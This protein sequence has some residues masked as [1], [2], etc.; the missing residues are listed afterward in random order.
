MTFDSMYLPSRTMATAVSSQLVSIPRIRVT[1]RRL[2]RDIEHD[3]TRCH[4]A[5]QPSAIASRFDL[6]QTGECR[7]AQLANESALGGYVHDAALVRVG[8]VQ[9]APAIDG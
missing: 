9:S 4:Q 8:Q 5:I 7:V 2:W 6:A 3:H 1:V